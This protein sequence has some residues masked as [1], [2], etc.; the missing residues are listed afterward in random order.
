[1]DASRGFVLV[2]DEDERIRETTARWFEDQGYRVASA[3]GEHGV[4]LARTDHPDVILLDAEMPSRH[5]YETLEKL[6]FDSATR[7]IPVVIFGKN[8]ILNRAEGGAAVPEKLAGLVQRFA[9]PTR[10]STSR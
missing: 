7:E 8:E 4:Q 1:M 6:K 5:G 3:N 2:I 10:I 9:K